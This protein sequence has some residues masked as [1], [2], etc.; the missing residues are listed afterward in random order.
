MDFFA[1]EEGDDLEVLEVFEFGLPR[2]LNERVNYFDLLDNVAFHRR[3]RL[4]HFFLACII[5]RPRPFQ[6]LIFLTHCHQ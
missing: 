1:L 3:F 6:L 5:R 2:K 4:T